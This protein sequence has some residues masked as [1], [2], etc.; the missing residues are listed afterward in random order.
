MHF[1]SQEAATSRLCPQG[2]AWHPGQSGSHSGS[3]QASSWLRLM[4]T[5]LCS[6]SFASRDLFLFTCFH[7]QESVT[8][9]QREGLACV[10]AVTEG[11]YG[12][13]SA[14]PSKAGLFEAKLW[15]FRD[16]WK[17]PTL[18]SFPREQWCEDKSCKPSGW[19]S[20]HKL[21]KLALEILF[22]YR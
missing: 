9:R 3:T 20:R 10:W 4:E 19:R 11:K 1:A 17:L 6:H 18:S 7:S 22:D 13:E 16:G 15:F 8:S 12:S 5:F 21:I 2:W 14:F